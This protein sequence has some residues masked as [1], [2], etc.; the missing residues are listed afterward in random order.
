[1]KLLRF[2]GDNHI[3]IAEGE[4]TGGVIKVSETE[5]YR[6]DAESI[7][8]YI[9]APYYGFGKPKRVPIVTT[10]VGDSTTLY[11]IE[12]NYLCEELVSE[13]ELKD[14]ENASFLET[15][16]KIEKGDSGNKKF[17]ERILLIVMGIL[18]TA[19]AVIAIFAGLPMFKD[20]VLNLNK[21]KP[22]EAVPIQAT[23]IENINGG[24]N[25][26]IFKEQTEL[27]SELYGGSN[28]VR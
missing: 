3:E 10:R 15:Q 23:P 4:L 8:F 1:M 14:F 25:N 6:A 12:E 2:F 19:F 7:G 28:P 27:N 18:G 22:I 11:P 9:S 26:G 21:E 13:E 5:A 16:L 20:N 17:Q 24:N